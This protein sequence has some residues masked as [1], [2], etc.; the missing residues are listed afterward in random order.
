MELTTSLRDMWCDK[1]KLK[2]NERQ[3]YFPQNKRPY[4][5][6]SLSSHHHPRWLLSTT[7]TSAGN[8]INPFDGN[9]IFQHYLVSPCTGF[10]NPIRARINK[11]CMQS[12]QFL[13][14]DAVHSGAVLA[15]VFPHLLGIEGNKK[16]TQ[17]DKCIWNGNHS[18]H[19]V[20]IV[21]SE[22]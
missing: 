2:V 7:C 8:W 1:T 15:G 10:A 4:K 13:S 14:S 19:R 6:P 22:Q 5:T 16:W 12:C 3:G 18:F 21:V 17:C 20:R 9:V 11:S